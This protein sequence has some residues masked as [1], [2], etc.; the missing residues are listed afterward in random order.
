LVHGL[1][2]T[3]GLIAALLLSLAPAA[4]AMELP[5]QVRSATGVAER[6]WREGGG[7]AAGRAA[8][9]K[10][11]RFRGGLFRVRGDVDDVGFALG[12]FVGFGGDGF[13]GETGAA[14]PST[15]A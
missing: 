9:E 15:S 8:G 13:R 10:L 6:G 3:Q 4:G 1:K 12:A 2:I 14:R 11:L 7:I 5:G